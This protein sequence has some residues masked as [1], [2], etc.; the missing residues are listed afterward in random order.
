[1]NLK[2]LVT[3]LGLRLVVV[4]KVKR[5]N[6]EGLHG[7]PYLIGPTADR[8]WYARSQSTPNFRCSLVYWGALVSSALP[9]QEN[10]ASCDCAMDLV[11]ACR[12]ADQGRRRLALSVPVEML[13]T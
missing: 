8:S 6:W 3:G 13:Q 10:W 4:K 11:Y 7:P 2:S 9:E 5:R 12:C 1:M